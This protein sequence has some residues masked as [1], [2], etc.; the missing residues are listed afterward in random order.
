MNEE[1]KLDGFLFYRS[2]YEA[3]SEL[4]P[5]DRTA[6]YDAICEMGLNGEVTTE[7]TGV[8]K[9][10]FT[11]I[12]PV[13]M[14]NRQK[15]AGGKK[16][17][18]P[19]KKPEP[20]AAEPAQEPEQTEEESIEEPEDS[21]CEGEVSE[22]EKPMVSKNNEKT[23]TY[24]YEK[25]AKNQ[26]HSLS[27]R[28]EIKD[29]EIKDKR[30]KENSLAGVKESPPPPALSGFGPFGNVFLSPHE[31]RQLDETYPGI[32]R[33]VMDSLSSYMES[34]GKTYRSHFATILRWVEK[35]QKAKK[36]KGPAKKDELPDWYADLGDRRPPEPELLEEVAALQAKS[37]AEIEDYRQ[38]QR[39]GEAGL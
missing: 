35:D 20:E 5:A 29:K 2:F 10:M 7:L 27:N 39:K 24:G 4:E 21:E 8:A 6:V 26:N 15:K 36:C 16:G 11:L 14:S 13:L 37:A 22:N 32:W 12:K 18:R 19:R 28:Q 33:P 31:I 23:K 34:T 1:M 3:L 38:Q 25:Q 9:A 30:F 17:G